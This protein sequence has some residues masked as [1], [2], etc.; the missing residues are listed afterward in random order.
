MQLKAEYGPTFNSM[1]LQSLPNIAESI[2]TI[3]ATIF[4]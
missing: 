4:S 3:S 2:M 1:I